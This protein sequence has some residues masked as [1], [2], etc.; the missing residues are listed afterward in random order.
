MYKYCDIDNNISLHDCYATKILYEN[1]N[2]TFVFPDGI[3]ITKEHPNNETD[4]TVR[5]DMAEVRYFLYLGKE[6][7]VIVYVFRQKFNK[8]IREEWSLSKLIEHVN[9]NN[10][11]L[12]FLYQYKNDVSRIIECSLWADKRPY[13]RECQLHLVIKD[14]KYYWNN[15]CEEKEC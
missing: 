6:C 9:N 14:V 8:T 10:C 7:D 1:G 12:E 11:R 4:K 13:S 5:T 3:W 15:L 2:L